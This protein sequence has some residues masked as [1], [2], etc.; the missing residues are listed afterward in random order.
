MADGNVLLVLIGA[1][2]DLAWRKF[3]KPAYDLEMN[4]PNLSTLLVDVPWA[5]ADISL[6]DQLRLRIG[7][8]LIELRAEDLHRA[9]F[10]AEVKPLSAQ[11][12]MINDSAQ[13][14]SQKFFVSDLGATPLPWEIEQFIAHHLDAAS[15]N[16]NEERERLAERLENYVEWFMGTSRIGFQRYSS[17]PMKLRNQIIELKAEGL[18]VAVFVAIPPEYYS[19]VVDQWHGL[20]DRIVLEKPAAGLDPQTLEYT[21]TG[22]LREVVSRIVAPAQCVSSDH[23]NAKLITR[24]M[25]RIRDY[26]LFDYLLDPR[27]VSRIVVELLES[28]PLPLGR[29]NF[30]NGAGGAFGDM[31]PH[32]F[33][34][35]RAILGLTTGALNVRFGDEF[36]RARYRNAPVENTFV[37]PDDPT[38]RYEPN[39]YRAL[40]NETETFVAF[41]A[42]LDVG[43]QTIPLY[44][45]TGKGFWPERKSLR[46]DCRYDDTGAELSLV[47]DFKEG[48]ITLWDHHRE[49][50]LATG[51]LSLSDYFQSGVPGLEP[52]YSGI[53]ECLVNSDWGPAALDTRY[54]PSVSDAADMADNVFGHLLA[55]RRESSPI[56]IYTVYDPASCHELLNFLAHKAHW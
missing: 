28:A 22:N 36:Y 4:Y 33:Q 47:F 17:D 29:C 2:G 12:D 14:P 6:E 40:N 3:L 20:A 18:K 50:E 9:Y 13:L 44:C 42:E 34:S 23:Y 8:R 10:Q 37:Y 1:L 48:S 43:G 51:R 32:L 19:Q 53:F 30:Y 52:E 45:R 56:H 15:G 24:A 27:R 7:R 11:T 35:V 41:E 5:H 31:V 38:Y 39:Y 49:F 16:V 54:F 25:D 26:H 21:G 46:V 55:K